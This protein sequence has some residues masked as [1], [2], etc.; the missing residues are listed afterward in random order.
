MFTTH[1]VS[2]IRQ[3]DFDYDSKVTTASLV[4]V[5]Q[6]LYRIL[7][8]A[9]VLL[10]RTLVEKGVYF[11][12]LSLWNVP[13]IGRENL[14]VSDVWTVKKVPVFMTKRSKKALNSMLLFTCRVLQTFFLLTIADLFSLYQVR[15]Y[16]ETSTSLVLD[17]TISAAVRVLPAS[18]IVGDLHK[19][20]WCWTFKIFSEEALNPAIKHWKFQGEHILIFQYIWIRNTVIHILVQVN[21]TWSNEKIRL[22]WTT[23]ANETQAAPL[24]S[25]FLRI[26]TLVV[27][28]PLA[29]AG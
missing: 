19:T 27:Y 23:P 29:G 2:K 13:N 22:S 25:G 15:W 11:G 5:M 17:L 4:V 7:L 6:F 3:N 1:I 20:N 18:Q 24:R 10:Q 28:P 12:C 8:H 21:I 16:R 26:E 9:A 14:S